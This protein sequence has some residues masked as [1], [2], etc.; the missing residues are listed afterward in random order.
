[1]DSKALTTDVE[2]LDQLFPFYLILNNGLQIVSVGRS[3]CKI[4]PQANQSLFLEAFKI[5]RPQKEI[6]RISDF[7]ELRNELVI[8]ETNHLKKSLL[9]R[10]TFHYRQRDDIYLFAGSPWLS[11][12]DEMVAH[13]LTLHDFA[14]QDPMVDFLHVLKNQEIATDEAKELLAKVNEQKNEIRRSEAKYRAIVETAAEMIYK[15]N[16]HGKITFINEPAERITG[17]SINELLQMRHLKLVE[18]DYRQMVIDF[19]QAQMDNSTA[20]SYLEFPIITK[21]GRKIW[22]G[23]SAQLII[24]EHKKCELTFVSIDIS[25]RRKVEEKLFREEEKYRNIIANMN[26]GLMEVDNDDKA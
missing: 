21:A 2:L 8:I 1:M 7:N 6:S 3:I 10:G 13:Q 16:E 26:L 17:Y 11:S 15:V 18:S 12:A 5:R 20:T 9:L 14:I 25:L 23:Q 22:L 24:N 19:Y 4:Y